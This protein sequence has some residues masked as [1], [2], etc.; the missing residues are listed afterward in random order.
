MIVLLDQVS[1]PHNIGA[2][3]R[4][5]AAFGALAVVQTERG[6]P[7]ATGIVAKSASG[8]LEAVPL[9]TVTNLARALDSLQRAG[10]WLIGLDGEAE[11]TLG[12]D[13]PF[14]PHRAGPWRRGQGA[15]PPY[16]RTLR[17]A[18]PPAHPA[19]D[20]Q[21]QYIERGG[22]SALRVEAGVTS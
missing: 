8:A 2:V 22:R 18:G 16:P 6:T 9:V 3:L 1:D 19:T 17:S 21:P 20:R 13:R 11:R 12:R 5:A 7:G 15:A 4:S 10:F 14:R